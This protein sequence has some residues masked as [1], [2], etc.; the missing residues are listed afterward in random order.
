MNREQFLVVAYY[1][2]F[3]AIIVCV[4]AALPYLR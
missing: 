3:V 1:I 2:V 4:M